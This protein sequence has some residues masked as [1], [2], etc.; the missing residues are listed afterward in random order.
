[1]A[2]QP[3]VSI[4]MPV[5]NGEQY[6]RGALDSLLA[7]DYTNFELIISDNASTDATAA[8]CREYAT[9]EARIRY[10]RAEVNNGA[11]WNFN[12]TFALAQGEYFMWAACDDLRHP[13]FIS[14]CLS[15]L[16]AQPRAVL[17]C[18]QIE[19]IDEAG[20][21]TAAAPSNIPPA[22]RNIHRRVRAIARSAA[23]YDIYGLIRADA[24]RQTQLMQPIWGMDVVL[25][26]EL[27]LLGD[28]ILVPE[29]L[30]CYR[31]FSQ[32]KTAATA[33]ALE[34]SP[35][36]S[37]I[38]VN[39]A[40]VALAMA[41]SIWIAS[42]QRPIKFSLIA[43]FL[44]DYCSLNV[45]MSVLD[46]YHSAARALAQRKPRQFLTALLILALVCPTGMDEA[47]SYFNYYTNPRY[48]SRRLKKVI[49]YALHKAS[50]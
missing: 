19:F 45:H 47:K 34:P 40:E 50:P 37:S 38:R 28:V 49:A 48:F 36:Q 29:K 13:H 12:Y 11:R 14:R 43:G 5:Y 30:F 26:L 32:K 17:C 21:T 8:I 25:L 46:A 42:L 3:L 15:A 18:S 23:W 22:G 44:L 1:M 24:L 33:A 39:N 6:L 2:T 27:C 20:H 7:Q 35:T 9:H 16:Q 41:H 4:G 10:H 31:I